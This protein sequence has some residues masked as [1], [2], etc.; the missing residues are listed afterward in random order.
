MYLNQGQATLLNG[1]VWNM[2]LWPVTTQNIK[3]EWVSNFYLMK[4][5]HYII[6][7]FTRFLK[8]LYIVYLGWQTSWIRPYMVLYSLTQGMGGQMDYF[9]LWIDSS[10]NHGHSKAKPKCTTYG[11]PQLSADP[12]FEVD[13]IEVWGLGPEKK[14]EEDSDEEKEKNVSR[15]NQTKKKK[16][17][18]L[19]WSRS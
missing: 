1:L 6:C 15:S 4:L 5:Q 19:L 17:F 13:I 16:R 8:W 14:E 11:S 18:V 7:I 12:E 10:F 2:Y 3:H 9:G